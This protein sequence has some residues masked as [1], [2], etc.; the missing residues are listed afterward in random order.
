[1]QCFLAQVSGYRTPMAGNSGAAPRRKGEKGLQRRAKIIETAKQRLIAYGL[2]GFVLRDIANELGITHG[3][4]QY[5]FPTKNELLKAIFDE[6][7]E[8]FTS[9]VRESMEP[10]SSPTDVISKIVDANIAILARDE[11]RLWRIL[12][13]VADQD[14]Y[15][16]QVLQQ[17]N[18]LFERVLKDELQAVA[19]HLSHERQRAV[20]KIVRLIIDGIGLE[21]V[22]VDP[23]SPAAEKLAE[24]VKRSIRQLLSL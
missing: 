10:A 4:L 18:E 11:T 16:A 15:L 14:P 3:N 21:F 19:G 9:A 5:Y 20:A 7:V 2:D 6:E 8:Q 22:Y 17:E 1:M 24:D 23:A 13:T 12:Y